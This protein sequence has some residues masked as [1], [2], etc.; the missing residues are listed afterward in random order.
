MEKCFLFEAEIGNLNSQSCK[1]HQDGLRVRK[2]KCL[3]GE[4]KANL[5]WTSNKAANHY[6]ITWEELSCKRELHAEGIFHFRSR[7]VSEITKVKRLFLKFSYSWK[8][9]KGKL[10]RRDI[11]GLSFF[12]NI[13]F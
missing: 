8:R 12:N 2:M 5:V 4:I 1:R 11:R 6:N 7:I 10:K 9:I 13:F 3:C